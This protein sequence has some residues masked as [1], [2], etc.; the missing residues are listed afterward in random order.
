MSDNSS[1]PETDI[2]ALK[3]ASSNGVAISFVAQFTRF[4][5]QFVSSVIMARLLSPPEFGIAAMAYP[6]LAFVGL[7][8]DLGLT[9]ATVQRR[10]IS[11]DELSFM[12]WIALCASTVVGVVVVAIAPLAASFYHE[13]RVTAV[14]MALGIITAVGGGYIQ[15]AALLNRRL[16]FGWIGIADVGSY[17]LGGIA[18][19]VAALSG[20]SYW[21][22]IIAQGV[23]TGSALLFYVGFARWM[24]SRP[25][26]V[27][28]ARSLLGFGGN[29]TA[30]NV[31]NYFARNLDNVLIGRYAGEAQLGLYD[32]AYRLLILPIQQVTQP[33]SRVATP[34]L[35]RMM[36]VPQDYRRSYAR[37]LEVSLLLTYPSVLY[38]ALD[39]ENLINTLLGANWGQVAP[40]F[41]I[42]AIGAFFAPIS[43]S[44]GWL[45]TTQDR[46]REMRNYG[47]LSSLLFVASFFVGLPGGALGVARWYIAAGCVQGPLL[48]WATMRR[49][50]VSFTHL[51]QVVAPF[52]LALIPAAAA[53]VGL[54]HILPRGLAQ[55]VCGLAGSYAAFLLTLL[56]TPRGRD[57]LGLFVRQ[58]VAVRQ[59]RRAALIA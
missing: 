1:V 46:T 33:L 34:M 7:F 31:I 39:R 12:F 13:P 26:R 58:A 24:P 4:G 27:E 3:R 28:S 48:W 56:C 43:N 8:V 22:I 25:R 20:L 19:I 5:L 59:R 15:H 10:E 32:R 18:G 41:G 38:A 2:A 40:I 23:T 37:V 54:G 11:Q 53:V 35:A 51:V 45:L 6:V 9:Q 47:L 52:A 36:E 50:P 44:T 57:V 55:I 17:V 16:Q 42:L 49:G 29:I 21:S 30:F 14:L